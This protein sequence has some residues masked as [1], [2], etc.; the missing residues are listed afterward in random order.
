MKFK[1]IEPR[2]EFG[3]KKTDGEMLDES[4]ILLNLYRRNNILLNDKLF[5]YEHN[6][7]PLK[8]E[9]I[10]QLKEH[11]DKLKQEVKDLKLKKWW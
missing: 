7:I 4:E 10:E 3:T 11:I 1:F 5:N 8:D 6:L 9:C 2:D